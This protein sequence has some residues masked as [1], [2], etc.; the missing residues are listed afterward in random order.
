MLDD[1]LC[2]EKMVQYYNVHLLQG[3]WNMIDM[4]QFRTLFYK[5]KQPNISGR[6][7]S[8]PND[9]PG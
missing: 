4:D 9:Y 8:K 7:T 5:Y 2:M 3:N 6:D 1:T